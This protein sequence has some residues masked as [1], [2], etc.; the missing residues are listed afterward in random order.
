M[1]IEYRPHSHHSYLLTDE[2]V[3]LHENYQDQFLIELQQDCIKAKENQ[4]RVV[5]Y[6][7]AILVI[8]VGIFVIGPAFADILQML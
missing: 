6:I 1:H 3:R 4:K 7:F 8:I 2:E 5:K